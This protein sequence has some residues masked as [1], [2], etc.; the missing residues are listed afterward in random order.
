[1]ISQYTNYWF[2]AFDTF[3]NQEEKMKYIELV[4]RK[5]R[6]SL[7]NMKISIRLGYGLE[8]LHQQTSKR[9]LQCQRVRAMFGE[10]VL[11]GQD[12]GIL[13]RQRRLHVWL[14]HSR[15][16][17]FRQTNVYI[18]FESRLGTYF[19]LFTRCVVVFFS[20]DFLRL[21]VITYNAIFCRRK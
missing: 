1:M 6:K 15:I 16:Y 7:R 17:V 8:W 11:L 18:E 2:I 4:Q 9:D 14:M 10:I 19:L 13:I 3:T 5:L 12:A 20:E 21:H